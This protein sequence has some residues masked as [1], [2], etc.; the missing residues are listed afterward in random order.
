MHLTFRLDENANARED[1]CVYF[2]KSL[3]WLAWHEYWLANRLGML[4][5]RRDF[6]RAAVNMHKKSMFWV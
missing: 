2:G 4:D 6:Q 1:C 3:T 5:S